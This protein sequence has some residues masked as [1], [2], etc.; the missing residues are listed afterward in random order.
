MYIVLGIV[1][2]VILLA[3]VLIPACIWADRIDRERER[4]L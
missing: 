2:G 4:K 3:W 1:A